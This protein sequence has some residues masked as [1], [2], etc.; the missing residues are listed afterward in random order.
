MVGSLGLVFL[1]GLLAAEGARR[2]HLP[3]LVGMLAVGIL[4]GPYVLNLLSPE[5]LGISAQLRQIALV[6]ILIR[7]GLSM[8]WGDLKQVGRP[9]LLMCFLPATL[10][11]IAFTLIGPAVLGVTAREGA[12]IGAV[13][14]AVS[15]AVVVPAMVRLIDEKQGTNK[16]IPQMVL[17]GSSADDVFV[18]VLFTSFL[19][20][21]QGG[22]I[23]AAD[24]A[25]I[26]IAMLL[27]IGAGAATGYVLTRLFAWAKGISEPV[28]LIIT[29]GASF[30]LYG[31]ESSL[32]AV[33]V[34]M[35]G[36]LGVMAMAFVLRAKCVPEM[37]DHLSSG[38]NK[39]WS[40]AEILLFVLVGA[41]VDIRYMVNAGI[42]AL[43]MIALG[44]L[45]RSIGTWIC[46]YGTNLNRKERL[47]CVIAYLPKATVQAAIGAVPLSMGL[48]CGSMT[49]SVAVLAILVTAPLGA[50]AIE[51]SA[52]RLLTRE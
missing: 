21:A 37:A 48:A 26:P 42:P 8:K 43:T 39:L 28:R 6:I 16:R 15:P 31:A 4:L 13:M 12:L 35:S 11:V 45:F 10:E 2:L 18:M 47:F 23:R 49:L 27:G 17:A 22:E 24:F 38:T 41:A 32:K 44:L 3:R 30:L 29:L 33:G 9:A 51:Q 5:L 40:A 25:Q 52:P 14:G 50:L 19:G 20:M 36:L 46:M 7:A 34:P 1:L